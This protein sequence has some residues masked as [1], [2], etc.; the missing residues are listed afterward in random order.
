MKQILCSKFCH[1]FF[2]KRED[3]YVKHFPGNVRVKTLSLGK[4]NKR[5]TQRAFFLSGNFWICFSPV[6][7][8]VVS[9]SPLEAVQES[10]TSAATPRT[11]RTRTPLPLFVAER[12]V[13]PYG[14]PV[15]RHR[16]IEP[17]VL[18]GCPTLLFWPGGAVVLAYAE[19]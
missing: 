12:W 19:I 2:W 17:S 15:R 8:K 5:W 4:Y 9:L 3:F 10:V 18:S 14:L 16:K 1:V 13:K 7:V 11:N 6:K